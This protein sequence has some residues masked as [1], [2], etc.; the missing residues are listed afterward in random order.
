MR[1]YHGASI[2]YGMLNTPKGLWSLI[3]AEV[4]GEDRMQLVILDFGLAEQLDP[5]VRFHFL[6]F[7]QM[8][9]KGD[10]VQAVSAF[11]SQAETL[12]HHSSSYMSICG[13]LECLFESTLS[14]LCLQEWEGDHC[15]DTCFDT[16]A[17]FTQFWPS[18]VDFCKI[19]GEVCV[20]KFSWSRSG[21]VNPRPKLNSHVCHCNHN[22]NNS[23]VLHVSLMS[24]VWCATGKPPS[25]VFVQEFAT[26]HFP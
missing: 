4:D 8:V 23:Y 1:Q 15:K 13:G 17:S 18:M 6:S 7:M 24:Y 25:R 19:L 10:G 5:T 14:F 26:M 21:F 11:F 3:D 12:Q 2:L 16:I 9:G 20:L 22:L